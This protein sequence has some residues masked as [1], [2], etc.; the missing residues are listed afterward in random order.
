M[1]EGGNLF[2][3]G[4]NVADRVQKLAEPG[5]IC[6]ARNVHDHLR[7]KADLTLEPMGEHQVKNIATPVAV[8]RVLVAG[9]GPAAA[10]SAMGSCSRDGIGARSG[11]G[12]APPARRRRALA[13][14]PL[15]DATPPRTDF[16]SA[17]RAAF[18]GLQPR[19]GA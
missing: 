14:W 6:I 17:G 19:R 7:N 15:L 4:V 10:A 8:Y 2:G 11:S 3:D 16:P 5:G 12:A 9:R 13:A 1:A 18:P